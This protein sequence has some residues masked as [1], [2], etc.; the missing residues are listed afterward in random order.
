MLA[1]VL[2]VIGGTVYAFNNPEIA[3][4]A[5]KASTASL[6]QESL[7]VTEAQAAQID[8]VLNDC[9][10]KDIIAI[11][12]DDL[13][14]NMTDNG[15]VGFRIKAK[16]IKNVILYLK[17]GQVFSI[18]YADYDIYSNSTKNYDLSSFYITFD[19]MLDYMNSCENQINQL[20]KSPS[21]AKYPLYDQWGFSKSPEEIVIQGYVDAQN[22]FGATLRSEFQFRLTP[23]ATTITSLI[24]EG[25]ELMD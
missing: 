18:R 9:G 24:F 20:L 10:V 12:R 6:T 16:E 8:V 23:D 11:E 15:E 14:D 21:T 7:G 22:A 1:F 13:L 5:E 4:K 2:L 17:D 3:K 19:E 25:E